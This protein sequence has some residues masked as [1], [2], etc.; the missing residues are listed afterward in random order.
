[1]MLPVD[2]KDDFW[3]RLLINTMMVIGVVALIAVAV[4][5]VAFLWWVATG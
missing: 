4:M 1:M 5:L 2:P 3:D